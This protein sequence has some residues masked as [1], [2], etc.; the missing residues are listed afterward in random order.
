MKQVT[1][2]AVCFTAGVGSMAA[3]AVPVI[4]QGPGPCCEQSIEWVTEPEIRH[5]DGVPARHNVDFFYDEDGTLVLV[6]ADL[7]VGKG[8]AVRVCG[9]APYMTEAV[10]AQ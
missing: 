2:G 9:D 3:V 8:H 7:L 4:N 6:T 5:A 10:K 1:V